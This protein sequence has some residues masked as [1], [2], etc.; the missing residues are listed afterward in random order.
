MKI[1]IKM[2]DSSVRIMALHNEAAQAFEHDPEVAVGAEIASWPKQDQ[3]GVESWRAMPDEA[4]PTDRTFRNAWADT[5]KELVIDHD[6]EKCREIWRN[7]M[8][9]VRAG[10]LAALDVE[11]TRAIEIGAPT[12]PIYAR[13]QA[14]RDVTQDPAIAAAATPEELKQFWPSI[15]S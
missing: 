3:T 6:M 7:R 2:N 10:K 5:S 13:K 8:R 14:L 15:L 9:K 1:V 11:T 12:Q 4:I